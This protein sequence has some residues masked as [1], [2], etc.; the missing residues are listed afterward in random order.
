M[1]KLS[2]ALNCDATEEDFT[3]NHTLSKPII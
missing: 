2:S 1:Q 3:I